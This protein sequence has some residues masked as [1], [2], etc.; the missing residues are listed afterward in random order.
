MPETEISGP[1]ISTAESE[2]SD[3]EVRRLRARSRR[4]L[5][6]VSWSHREAAAVLD[7]FDP[8][9]LKAFSPQGEASAHPYPN[10]END[11]Q[12]TV[13]PSGGRRWRLYSTIRSEGLRRL[14]TRA[15]MA[16]ALRLNWNGRP[17]TALQAML[18]AVIFGKLPDIGSLNREKLAALITVNDWL[19]GILPPTE[20]PPREAVAAAFVRE[21]ALAPYRRLVAHGFVGRDRELDMLNQFINTRRSDA[22]HPGPMIIFGIGGI[23]KS[24]L[25]A[26]FL[27]DAITEDSTRHL[28]VGHLD[29]DDPALDPQQPHTLILELARQVGIHRPALKRQSED[30]MQQIRERGG[31]QT[32][33]EARYS[34]SALIE[35]SMLKPMALLLEDAYDAGVRR[36]II[37]VDT[38]ER[39]P[40]FGDEAVR[41]VLDPL[42]ELSEE[43]F[44]E[45]RLILSGRVS[46]AEDIPT[47]ATETRRRPLELRA[48]EMS[49]ARTL[50]KQLVGGIQLSNNDCDTILTAVGTSPLSV[51]LAARL[52]QSHGVHAFTID[53]QRF[54][55]ALHKEKIEVFL[56]GRV[57]G[58]L[59]DRLKPIAYP[60]L[61]VR[62]ITAGV[63]RE[64]LAEP[65]GLRLQDGGTDAVKD[66][67]QALRKERAL[68]DVERADEDEALSDREV[69]RYR[70]DL[71]EEVLPDVLHEVDPTIASK[72]DKLAVEYYSRFET[73]E[74][75]TEEL[76]HRLRLMQPPKIFDQHWFAAARRLRSSIDE[77]P[78]SSRA[79]L[80]DKLGQAVDA[81]A[82]KV[83]S[84]SVRERDLARRVQT[85]VSA[86]K[87]EEALRLLEADNTPT[88]SFRLHQLEMHALRM[89]RRTMD[90]L[91]LALRVA[92]TGPTHQRIESLLFAAVTAEG[93]G[94][95]QRAFEYS[96]EAETLADQEG[97]LLAL[98]AAVTK[99]RL[100]RHSG[101]TG[102]A[103]QSCLEKV[104]SLARQYG[105][106]QLNRNPV[107]L[108]EVAAEIGA[109]SPEF[110]QLAVERL[111][112]QVANPEKQIDQLATALASLARSELLPLR[113][114]ERRWASHANDP[115]PPTPELFKRI[116]QAQR[117]EI[118]SRRTAAALKLPGVE[119]NALAALQDFFRAAVDA[120]VYQQSPLEVTD[121]PAV[122]APFNRQL[123]LDLRD[124]LLDA[125][126]YSDLRALAESRLAVNLERVTAR[127]SL[128]LVAYELIQWV[129]KR[130]RLHELVWAAIESRPNNPRLQEIAS[131]LGLTE[132]QRSKSQSLEHLIENTAFTDV[133]LFHRELGSLITYVCWVQA[134]DN[135]GTGFLVGEDLVLTC[136]H[137][138]ENILR[139]NGVG[140]CTFDIDRPVESGFQQLSEAISF[141]SE[142]LVA[143]SP[144]APSD[145]GVD[146]S[147]PAD[148]LDYALIRLSTSVGMRPIGRNPE[149]R[150]QARGWLVLPERPQR[151]GRNDY[152]IVLS[153][154]D[155]QTA[156]ISLG[157]G[158]VVGYNANGTRLRHTAARYPRSGSLC[159]DQR[160]TPVAIQ[161]GASDPFNQAVPLDLIVSD[162][163]SKVP[164]VWDAMQ[165]STRSR[166]ARIDETL[167][168]ARSLGADENLPDL[169]A[170]EIVGRL[171]EQGQK[172]DAA[173]VVQTLNEKAKEYRAL[174][175]AL[176]KTAE[177]DDVKVTQFRRAAAASIESGDFAI[178]DAH[179]AEAEAHDLELA[180]EDKNLARTRRAS[181]ARSRGA[182]GDAAMLRVVYREAADHYAEAGRIIGPDD[183]NAYWPWL[184]KQGAALEV[185][186]EEFGDNQALQSAI[187]LF[188]QCLEIIDRNRAPL[189]WAETQVALGNALTILGSRETG[190][191]RVA[192]AIEEYRKALTVYTS[193]E[194]RERWA[195][196]QNNLGNAL[197]TLGEREPGT[198]S[199]Q[200]AVE[201]YRAALTVRTS[202]AMPA[203]W[204][205][206]VQN[207]G[208][209]LVALGERERGDS[210]LQDA[211]ECYRAALTVRR[212]EKEP[213]QWAMVQ[214]NLGHAL[215]VLGDRRRD[216]TLLEEA[217]YAFRAALIERT[218]MR[219]PLQ[220]AL[221]QNNL[222]NALAILGE[223]ETGTSR[224]DEAIATY[225]SAITQD[226]R[227]RAPLQ[228][229]VLQNNLAN[230]LVVRAKRT[231]D[232]P[233]LREA[234]SA[235]H[236]ALTERLRE[237]VPLQ[238]ATTQNELGAAMI[239][240]AQHEDSATHLA[241]AIDFISSAL[242][243]CTRERVPLAWGIT[244]ANLGDA[245]GALAA[246]E[247]G[248]AALQQAIEAYQL[249]LLELT[250]DATPIQ[251]AEVSEKLEAAVRLLN[252]RGDR[253]E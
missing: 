208:N 20:L 29:M 69:F 25:L 54:L 142:W 55:D 15:A 117:G 240:L 70:A 40:R 136:Y 132:F 174:K 190:P 111:G 245:Y 232:I 205:A 81:D 122:P 152:L 244:Q 34:E 203:Q 47:W 185:L 14:G 211:I 1:T 22:S 242:S 164:S 250:Q 91:E 107:L 160:L 9:T 64:V 85:L 78:A 79:W 84:Q 21:D 241:A 57:L 246:H 96:N 147:E 113:P 13:T 2:A 128:D 249:A 83:A 228:W 92:A 66:L 183:A 179:L 216:N 7:S 221:T 237:R 166:D 42:I 90:A 76:Y 68:V 53:R 239:L 175:E 212:R 49:A 201:A 89:A 33:L 121:T 158:K 51:R 143:S 61:I 119:Y 100:Y 135:A 163:R 109:S 137:V 41:N 157:V 172:H 253:R 139:S 82:L 72:I 176:G 214:N 231:V 222:G 10:H 11:G 63:I 123:T 195:A 67:F 220:W 223:R 202:E 101:Q 45:A 184:R 44:P 16:E 116:I 186:G 168:L 219:A 125:F 140:S 153:H 217:V 28:L 59:D 146:V 154:A 4:R 177:E 197:A 247:S 206:T 24:T 169:V 243:E 188:E 252:Q 52:I 62:Q 31:Q 30:V 5:P 161:H 191:A 103:F 144:Y 97:V 115:D 87:A 56:F 93:I 189:D 120:S 27:L 80:S 210:R 88:R 124:A 155:S 238:W 230:A 129:Q 94:L 213:L 251:W 248:T 194:Q 134:G 227:E 151:L 104:Q 118:F 204:A 3:E 192:R 106:R 110:L 126:S 207:L 32:A 229:A 199:L 234:I 17:E 181:A 198:T 36:Y 39:V 225:R 165:R 95:F 133:T 50:L 209:A 26:K 193:P 71:R 127:N 35:E 235:Y 12:P 8:A 98:R 37:V 131:R 173:R 102:S 86:G 236:S 167:D 23:G 159:L 226:L 58:D 112:L 145:A 224:L 65:C 73:V 171:G 178:A 170:R 48:L 18:D 38:F 141:A 148:K 74:A 156:P 60:G 162:I 215:Q 46:A 130:G 200:E 233:I 77:L 99:A 43:W 180:K 75:R 114:H 19:S 105:E 138:I 196:A 6:L 149:P 187:K 218:Q 108:T 150:A 182:R